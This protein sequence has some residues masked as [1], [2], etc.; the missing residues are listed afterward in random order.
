MTDEIFLYHGFRN[1]SDVQISNGHI[2]VSCRGEGAGG[3]SDGFYV[4]NNMKKS[5]EYL[6]GYKCNDAV[7]CKI[8]VP[9]KELKYPEW[10]LDYEAIGS[11]N[12]N[13][14]D[15]QKEFC[16]KLAKLFIKYRKDIPNHQQELSE[17]PNGFNVLRATE[18]KWGAVIKISPS[19]RPSS[20]RGL[21]EGDMLMSGC[22]QALNDYMCSRSPGYLAEYNS[23]LK[24]SLSIYNGALKYIGDKELKVLDVYTEEG[25]KSQNLTERFLPERKMQSLPISVMMGNGQLR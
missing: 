17:L 8:G 15:K 16:T 11:F 19:D 10:Q 1:A 14:Y 21:Y 5:T 13:D 2:P 22:E 24:E 25:K 3:Q 12:D 23:L 9:E 18:T 6:G 4:W 7:I 20:R